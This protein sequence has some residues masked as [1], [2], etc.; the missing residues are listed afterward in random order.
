MN[1][2]PKLWSEKH[3][4]NYLTCYLAIMDLYIFVFNS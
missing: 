3:E 4:M 2:T 1:N